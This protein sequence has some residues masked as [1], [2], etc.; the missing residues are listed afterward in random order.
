MDLE[1]GA[2]EAKD[3][4]LGDGAVCVDV[5]PNS[6]APSSY[7]PVFV[8]SQALTPSEG[9]QG[10]TA[11]SRPASPTVPTPGLAAPA[12]G[13]VL[14]A[15]GALLHGAGSE[16]EASGEAEESSREQLHIRAMEAALL[17]R[18][19]TPPL[20]RTGSPGGM[21]GRGRVRGRSPLRGA[22]ARG[23]RSCHTPP[24][25]GEERQMGEGHDGRY[26][27]GTV[28]VESVRNW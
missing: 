7:H 15:L 16:S 18:A 12:P 22:T 8:L 14:P 25:G 9:R 10:P 21:A 4:R 27:R 1:V 5:A 23:P 11:L 3:A 26:V 13:L 20:G 6:E 17:Q 24:L 19:R 2:I 28:F